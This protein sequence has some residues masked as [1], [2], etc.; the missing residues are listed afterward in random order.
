MGKLVNMTEKHKFFTPADIPK[1]LYERIEEMEPYCQFQIFGPFKYQA[2]GE[3]LA[4]LLNE[5]SALA[6]A[7]E[8]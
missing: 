7:R 3:F 4:N 1:T 6:T 2:Y 5:F 8:E